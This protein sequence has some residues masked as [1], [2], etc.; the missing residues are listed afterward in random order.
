[1]SADSR[2]DVDRFGDT[3][4]EAGGSPANDPVDMGF[5]YARSFQDPTGTSGR[6]SRWTRARSSSPR[7]R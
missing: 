4:L 2:E 1:M 3:A 6:S 7:R 5:M